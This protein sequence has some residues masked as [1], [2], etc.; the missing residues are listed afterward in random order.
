M[1]FTRCLTA[2]EEQDTKTLDWYWFD[3]IETL[4]R[5]AGGIGEMDYLSLFELSEDRDDASFPYEIGDTLA[6]LRDGLIKSRRVIACA[7]MQGGM[8]LLQ[9]DLC[10]FKNGDLV[11]ADYV[12]S[13][14]PIILTPAAAALTA[15]CQKGTPR[16]RAAAS[17]GQR[18]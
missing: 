14:A 12:K 4:F 13:I 15:Y 2:L 16:R 9:R 5:D 17:S 11:R 6:E 10:T 8:M 1:D 7:D 18:R 3:D